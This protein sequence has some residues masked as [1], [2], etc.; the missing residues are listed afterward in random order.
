MSVPSSV[1]VPGDSTA[2]TSASFHADCQGDSCV[3]DTG[4][5]LG[6]TA[7]DYES[8]PTNPIFYRMVMFGGRG[9]SIFEVPQDRESVLKLVFDSADDAERTSCAAIP[10]AYNAVLED[11]HA[12]VGGALWNSLEDEGDLDDIRD[13]NDPEKDGCADQGDGTPGACPYPGT[14]DAQSD[15]GGPDFEHVVTGVACGRL[16][17][18]AATEKSSMAWLYDITNIASPTLIK[19]FHLSPA[20]Q[21]KSPG[22]AYDDGTIGDLG[23]EWFYFLSPQDSPSGKAAVMFT[24]GYS[25]TLSFW[26]FDC[27]EHDEVSFATDEQVLKSSGVTTTLS[28]VVTLLGL[29]YGALSL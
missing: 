6:S 21:F 10:W 8:D 16:V 13:M 3:G 28:L 12:P 2:G 1:F 24:G 25:G 26:E 9:W 15:G 7:I 18:I 19:N 22:L 4:I 17:A 20:N 14:V 27:V 11:V 5:S 23:P 29:A